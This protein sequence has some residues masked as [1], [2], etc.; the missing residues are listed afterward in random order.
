MYNKR[1]WAY[2]EVASDDTGDGVTAPPARRGRKPTAVT[3][4]A[5]DVESAA[6]SAPSWM[7]ATT[8]KGTSTDGAGPAV[9]MAAPPRS[10]A[11]VSDRVRHCPDTARVRPA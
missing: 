9:E 1:N 11:Q 6:S 5:S 7:P 3:A 2:A 10:P 8:E 4:V